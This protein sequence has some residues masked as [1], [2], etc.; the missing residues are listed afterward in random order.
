V[1]APILG[2]LFGLCAKKGGTPGLPLNSTGFTPDEG[3]ESILDVAF[4]NST[5]KRGISLKMGLFS[6]ISGLSDTSIY[7]DITPVT[8]DGYAEVTI[9]EADWTISNGN[10]VLDRKVFSATG[11]N[12]DTVYGYYIATTGTPQRLLHVNVSGQAITPTTGQDY[13]VEHTTNLTS[14]VAGII[15]TEGI[16]GV[17]S[18][19]Y[20]LAVQTSN[21][22]IDL[23]DSVD[24]I[25]SA[26]GGYTSKLL[27]DGSWTVST[28][29]GIPQATYIQQVWTP[30][31]ADYTPAVYGYNLSRISGTPLFIDS[32]G[33]GTIV[34][35]GSEYIVTLTVS[36]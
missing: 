9:D 5:T 2:F 28:V 13:G 18:A 26:A 27:S 33:S 8:G 11:T 23:I 15:T 21:Y 14:G 31:V 25:I 16:D 7:A 17:L 35:N 24:S 10:A 29:G 4:N 34:Y 32:T 36:A 12:W 19:Y 20:K 6:N 30:S 22:N 1:S 3:M